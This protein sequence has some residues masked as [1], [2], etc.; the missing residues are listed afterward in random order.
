MHAYLYVSTL[1]FTFGYTLNASR[2]GPSLG[3]CLGCLF[4]A[5]LWPLFLPYF[6]GRDISYYFR[7]K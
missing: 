4:L 6:L 7:K 3:D 1:I 2:N 5:V